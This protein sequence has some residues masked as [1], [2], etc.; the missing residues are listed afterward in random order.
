MSW[1]AVIFTF[2]LALSMGAEACAAPLI[3]AEKDQPHAVFTLDD[4]LDEAIEVRE[5]KSDFLGFD[6]FAGWLAPSWQIRLEV[7]NMIS[8]LKGAEPWVLGCG[9]RLHRRLCVERC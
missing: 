1:Y 5:A 4:D 7:T 2:F 9:A 6:L 8:S 3:V